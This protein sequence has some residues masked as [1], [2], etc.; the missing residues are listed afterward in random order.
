MRKRLLSCP[1]H[2]LVSVTSEHIAICST[3]VLIPALNIWSTN[4]KQSLPDEPYACR[5]HLL[6]QHFKTAR[7]SSKHSVH[8]SERVAKFCEKNQQSG[9]WKCYCMHCAL[10][11][12]WGMKPLHCK[13]GLYPRQICN[14]SPWVRPFYINIYLIKIIYKRTCMKL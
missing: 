11:K 6:A 14:P 10:R 7:S 1:S 4:I 12:Q 9:L 13:W 3:N 8:C 5:S 2:L